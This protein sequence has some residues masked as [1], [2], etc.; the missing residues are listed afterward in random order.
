[1]P[2]DLNHRCPTRRQRKGHEKILEIV[3]ENFS[4]MGKGI[5][6]Q[7]QVAQGLPY[8]INPKQILPRH[9]LTKFKKLNTK[10]KY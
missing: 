3:A 5:A 8:R 1:M 9:L 2:H 6:T 7:V 4:K 10:S